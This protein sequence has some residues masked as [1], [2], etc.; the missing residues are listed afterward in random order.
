ME[1]A[2]IYRKCRLE[3]VQLP[4]REGSLTDVPMDD[5]R[6]KFV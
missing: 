6:I 3:E 4:L 1:R 5:V 2:S